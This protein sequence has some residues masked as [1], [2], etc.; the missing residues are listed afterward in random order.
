[1]TLHTRRTAFPAAVA[2]LMCLLGAAFVRAQGPAERAPLSDEVFKNVQLM[3][4]IP[5]DEFMNTMVLS[6]SLGMSC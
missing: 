2:L 6:A 1:M 5:V 3:K 4:G